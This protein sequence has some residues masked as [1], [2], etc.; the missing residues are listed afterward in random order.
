MGEKTPKK[1]DRGD[2]S[3]AEYRLAEERNENLET[4]YYQI[5]WPGS[6]DLS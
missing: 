4:T 2:E 6:I 3:E 1:I 5:G